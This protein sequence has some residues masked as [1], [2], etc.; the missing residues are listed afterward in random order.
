[1]DNRI[2]LII[3]VLF[4]GLMCS[5]CSKE[6]VVISDSGTENVTEQE[7]S[8]TEE[9]SAG[10]ENDTDKIVVFVCGSVLNEGVYEL[11]PG[12]R[13]N[14]ALAAAGG[15]AEDADTTA[16]NL[17]DMVTDGG[18]IYFPAEGESVS[19]GY[20]GGTEAEN[21]LTENGKVNINTADENGLTQLPGIGETR[22]RRIIAYRQEHGLFSSTEDLKNVSG[23]GDSIYESLEEYISVE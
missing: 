22:A 14:D 2:R 17:A 18:K 20:A 15:F 7:Q 9:D 16:V 4:L 5:G 3:C 10:S 1:M 6:T 12:A 19:S 11:D 8:D 13:V 23:I 21:V